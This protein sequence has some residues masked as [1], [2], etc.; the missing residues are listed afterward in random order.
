MFEQKPLSLAVQ[1]A[2]STVALTATAA[3]LPIAAQVIGTVLR[4]GEWPIGLRAP[5]VDA[6]QLACGSPS[7]TRPS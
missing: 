6:H 4:V 5:A 2:L 1:R 7:A 3:S